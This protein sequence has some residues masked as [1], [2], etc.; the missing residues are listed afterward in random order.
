MQEA[1][2]QT[3]SYHEHGFT[4]KRGRNEKRFAYFLSSSWPWSICVKTIGSQKVLLRISATSKR[5]KPSTKNEFACRLKR[6]PQS[7][8]QNESFVF[9]EEVRR[10][11]WRNSSGR[12]VR[13][14]ESSE[15][16]SAQ[17]NEHRIWRWRV[18]QEIELSRLRRAVGFFRWCAYS[19]EQHLV[20]RAEGLLNFAVVWRPFSKDSSRERWRSRK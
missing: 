19:F 18:S 7:Q 3:E 17:N 2:Q 10:R 13:W 5:S 1:D 6:K 11:T 12:V 14:T 8:K 9:E 15:D 20:K 4:W 16:T